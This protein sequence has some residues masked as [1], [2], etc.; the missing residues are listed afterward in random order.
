ME[1][2]KGIATCTLLNSWAR[3]ALTRCEAG[4]KPN[5]SRPR[6]C[7]IN[8]TRWIMSEKMALA[9]READ[10]ID[11]RCPKCNAQL[12]QYG[13]WVYCSLVGCDFGLDKDITIDELKSNETV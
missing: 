13:Q 4:D 11:E 8:L 1:L 9:E 3:T 12:L 2:A 7:P 6:A 5:N 10:W